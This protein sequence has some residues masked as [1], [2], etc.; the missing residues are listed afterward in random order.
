[1]FYPPP[2]HYDDTSPYGQLPHYTNE[3]HRYQPSMDL[4]D[5]PPP[6]NI[7]QYEQHLEDLVPN[8][9]IGY[10]QDLQKNYVMVDQR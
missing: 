5:G 8:Q 6:H 1:M 3:Q 7:Q 9:R 10:Q 4:L 2:S